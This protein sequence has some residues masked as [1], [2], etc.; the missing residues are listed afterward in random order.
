ML[1]RSKMVEL[2]LTTVQDY[3]LFHI[4]GDYSIALWKEQI[5]LIRSRNGL[6]SVGTHPDY[7]IEPRARAVYSDL[8]GYLRTL[9]EG[10][11]IWMAL[12]GEVDRWWRSRN[13]MTVVRSGQQ[14][15]IKGPESHRARIAF[16]MFKDG[17]LVYV[18]GDEDSASLSA[19]SRSST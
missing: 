6:I 16:A 3:S 2:P 10:G 17:R 8:L 9:R 15:R 4:I 5:D 1:F 13:Q 7:L 12:P 14:W 18:L 19:S 11:H